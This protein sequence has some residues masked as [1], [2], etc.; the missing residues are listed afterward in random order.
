L[1]N[2]ENNENGR[3]GALFEKEPLEILEI[4]LPFLHF[5]YW[6]LFLH[7]NYWSSEILPNLR[8]PIITH[9]TVYYFTQEK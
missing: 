2:I 6:V 7:S 5:H 3:K 8:N 1:Q 4:I 9:L